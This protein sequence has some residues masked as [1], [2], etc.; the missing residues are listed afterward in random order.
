MIIVRKTGIA[1]ATVTGTLI[2][3]GGMILIESW[4]ELGRDKRVT[5]SDEAGTH[6]GIIGGQQSVKINNWMLDPNS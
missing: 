1:T 5:K 4:T 3:T 2:R 6:A